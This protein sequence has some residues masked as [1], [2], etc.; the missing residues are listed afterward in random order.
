MRPSA[1][2]S[3]G[4]EG[5]DP[6]PEGEWRGHR[7][8]SLGLGDELEFGAAE[9]HRDRVQVSGCGSGDWFMTCRSCQS[10]DLDRR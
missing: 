7:V 8:K 4:H 10:R 1:V 3:H 5:P 6:L 9:R 2:G